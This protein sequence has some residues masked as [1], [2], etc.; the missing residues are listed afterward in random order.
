MTPKQR[1][2]TISKARILKV[3]EEIFA[4]KGFDGAR[5]DEI[6]KKAGVNKA[7]LYYYFKSKDALLDE[8]FTAAI[9]DIIG[10]IEQTYEDFQLDDSEIERLFNV[11]VNALIQKRRIIRVI[12]MESLKESNKKPYIFKIADFFL[13]SEVNTIIQ[14]FESK[15]W[16]LPKSHEKKQMLVT[17]FF[18]GFIPLLTYVVFQND[19]AAHMNMNHEEMKNRFFEAFKMTHMAYH[20]SVLRQ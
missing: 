7:L 13:G 8:L 15:G 9:K 11:M 3:A 20:R 18:T 6:A 4:D 2:A 12:L 17:E 19:L 5:V 10:H 16:K 1:D 14:L